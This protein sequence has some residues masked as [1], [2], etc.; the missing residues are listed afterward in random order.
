[1]NRLAEETSPYLLQHRDNPVDW[2]PWGPE[3]LAEAARRQQPILLSVGYAACHW[4]HVMAHESFEDPETAALM[5]RLYV[6][7]KVDREERPDLDQIYQH[8]LALLGEH[9]GWPLTMFLTPAGEPFWGGTYFPPTPRFNRPSFRDVLEGLSQIWQ[10][11]QDKVRKN[12]AALQTALERWARPAAGGAITPALLDQ[13]ADRLLQELDP[14][15]GGIGGAPKFPNAPLLNLFWRAWWRR[16]ENAF[17]D[18]V[19]LTLT[20]MCNGG[21]YDHLAG[22]FA[23]YTVDAIWLVPHFEKMLYDNGQLLELLL[24]AYAATGEPLFAARA[25]QTADWLLSEMRAA[26]VSPGV[27]ANGAPEPPFVP[28]FA[29]SYDADSE[30][31]EGKFYVWDA[32]ELEALLPP[33]EAAL[34][35]RHYDVTAAG[36]FEGHSIL[37]RRHAPPDYASAEGR[38]L[39]AR[40]AAAAATLRAARASR[41]WPGWDD[42]VL[43]DWNGLAI[44]ALVEAAMLLG[45]PRWLAA[46]QDALAFLET[47]LLVGGRLQHSWRHGTA[48]HR[49]T[50]DDLALLARA[51]L[52]LHEATGDG[53]ALALAE[54]LA[55]LAER[56]HTDPAGGYYLVADD[57]EALVVRQKTAQD[58]AV[59]AGNG[60]IIEVLARLHYLTGAPAWRVAAE[61]AVTAF[62]GELER[63]FFPLATLLNATEFLERAC[64]VAIVGRRGEPATDALVAAAYAA[65]NPWR[66]LQVVA[67]GQAL[68]PGHPAAGKGQLDGKA[69]AYVC[70]GP[71][72]SLPLV[73]AAELTAALSRRG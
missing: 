20:R 60:V 21:I 18:G 47:Q 16:D 36:N 67:P 14:V 66:V 45:E 26:A 39:E 15:E 2:W 9:G 63:N 28:A 7:I 19:A 64:Q 35:M 40:L 48:K 12:V 51:A 8:A 29:A 24:Q 50:L 42:K 11:G 30:G 62:S 22:G 69:T 70:R 57:A 53:G 68:P 49:A 61:R 71:V 32:A 17:R 54:R 1:M 38:A 56:H 72:C 33:A 65:G 6:N 10:Q 4:C 46:A 59:P 34:V 25:R 31:H 58:S 37:N 27:A 52:L 44:A 3:A 55:V 43:A 23:R 13:V 73:E 41:V 5:N